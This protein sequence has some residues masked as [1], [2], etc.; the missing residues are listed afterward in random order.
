M[1]YLLSKIPLV[2]DLEG[3]D[4]KYDTKNIYYKIYKYIIDLQ[5]ELKEAKQGVN[6]SQGK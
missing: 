4:L 5:K 3:N 6:T 2:V 1:E